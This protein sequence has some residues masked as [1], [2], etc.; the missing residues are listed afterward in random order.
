MNEATEREPTAAEAD[1]FVHQAVQDWHGC[2]LRPAARV[3]ME[4]AERVTLAPAACVAA[5]ITNLRSAGWSDAAIHDAA[6]VVAYFNY[7]NRI[8]DALGVEPED[9]L[10]HWGAGDSVSESATR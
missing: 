8:A 3:L 6:Q 5:D 2:S 9:G 1:A 7:I 4:F 10:P